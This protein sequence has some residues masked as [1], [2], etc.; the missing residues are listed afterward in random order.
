MV[1][2]AN[3]LLDLDGEKILIDCGLH[4][5]SNFCEKH[6]WEPFPYNPAEIKAVFVTHAHIDHIG[7]LPKLYKDGFRGKVYSTPPTKDFGRLLLLDSDHILE[8]EARH[9]RRPILFTQDDVFGLMNIWETV[10]YHQPITVGSFK[11]TFYNAGHILGSSFI[12]V[13]A[14]GEKII[15]SG[16][17]GNSP[18][19]II[20]PWE[21]FNDKP[22]YCLIESTYGD[23]IHEDVPMR[24]EI[25]EDLIEDT[26]KRGGVLM[27]PAFA[28]ERT[29]ELLFEINNLMEEGRIPHVP[30]FL[31]SP[32]AIKLT[33]VYQRYDRYFVHAT[34][35]ERTKFHPA[36]MFKFKDLK[37]TMTT[38]ESK[39]IN[40]VPPPKVIIAGSG[41]S[42]GGRIL[43]HQKRYLPDHKSTLLIVGYQTNGSLGRRLLSG[44]TSV[45]IFGEDVPVRARIRAI[46]AYSAH[47]DQLQL[48]EWLK[49]MK[50]TLKKIFMVQGEEIPSETLAQKVIDE[51]AVSAYVPNLGE[52]V[53]L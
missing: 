52:E 50:L 16:D 25:I 30:V 4:Q 21:I 11:V 48:M 24:K 27:I 44:E 32:L 22:T 18:A 42:H 38:D 46:G 31:D 19:P 3:Y 45:R 10:E 29:Q 7:R 34:P 51:L 15:F 47:A 9:F 28:M 26:V 39:I 12:L 8:E 40:D 49:P 5:G 41:M 2:G 33:E 35:E 36:H 43:H 23:R 6:N 20:G 37:M 53:V 14:Q 13:E 17:L 1:T